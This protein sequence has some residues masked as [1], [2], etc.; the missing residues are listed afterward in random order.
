AHVRSI[1][2]SRWRSDTGPRSSRLPARKR[3]QIRGTRASVVKSTSGGTPG[4]MMAS[5]ACWIS[6]GKG[7]AS[8]STRRSVT[9]A[10]IR[11]LLL[12]QVVALGRSRV[13]TAVAAASPELRHHEGDELLDGAGRVDGREHEPVAAHRVEVR[14]HLVRHLRGR[15]DH[16]EKADALPVPLRHLAQGEQLARQRA[17]ARLHALQLRLPAM[18]HEGVE[19]DLRQVEVEVAG[20]ERESALE[21]YQGVVLLLL[22]ARVPLALP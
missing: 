9:K 13:L 18:R 14:L 4:G 19:R 8:G 1:T 7:G 2:I 11:L 16:L 15:A 17:V 3:S 20:E 5:N 21:R 6:G 22:L 10:C 12:H